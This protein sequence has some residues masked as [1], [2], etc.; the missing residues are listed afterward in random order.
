M[1]E[2]ASDLNDELRKVCTLRN[3]EASDLN[4]ELRKVCT[5]RNHDK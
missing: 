5:L 2:E 3:H 1:I 4:D